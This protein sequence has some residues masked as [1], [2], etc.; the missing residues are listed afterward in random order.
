MKR[1]IIYTAFGAALKIRR[2]AVNVNI[3]VLFFSASNTFTP[4]KV[5]LNVA[6][7]TT[8][9]TFLYTLPLYQLPLMLDCFRRPAY[10][11]TP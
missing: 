10:A 11:A 4:V 1:E 9:R 5:V 8:Y 7:F 2:V 6:P 3:R